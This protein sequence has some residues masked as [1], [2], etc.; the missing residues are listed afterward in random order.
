M[1]EFRTLTETVVEVMQIPFTV[2]GFE[3]SFWQIWLFLIFGGLV[4]TF[5]GRL[6]D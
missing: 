6:F 3:I 1:D 4:I 2:F 5:I